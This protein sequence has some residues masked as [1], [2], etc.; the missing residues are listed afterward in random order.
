MTS[1]LL[2]RAYGQGVVAEENGIEHVK[3]VIGIAYVGRYN[4]TKLRFW[5]DTVCTS[6]CS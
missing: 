4:F 1:K 2:E 6:S 3:D 5:I